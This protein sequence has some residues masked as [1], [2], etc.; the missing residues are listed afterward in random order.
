MSDPPF[1]LQPRRPVLAARDPARG[2]RTRGPPEGA[3]RRR[4]WRGRVGGAP[5][6]PGL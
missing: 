6:S 5:P 4:A 2:V 1:R 3:R